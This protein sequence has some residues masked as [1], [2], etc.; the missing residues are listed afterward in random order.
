MNYELGIFHIFLVN[1]NKRFWF[2]I[3][4]GEK[5][6]VVCINAERKQPRDMFDVGNKIDNMLCYLNLYNFVIC[7]SIEKRISRRC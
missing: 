4:F 3:L 7:Y 2:C 5:K 6:G 1:F